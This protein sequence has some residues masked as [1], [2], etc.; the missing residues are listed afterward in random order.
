V[1]VLLV[2]DIRAWLDDA[3][4]EYDLLSAVHQSDYFRAHILGACVL[5]CRNTCT[6][7]YG[8]MYVDLDTI[9]FDTLDEWFALL[10][11]HTMVNADWSPAN[12]SVTMGE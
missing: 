5:R 7:A 12:E 8:G 2:G 6:A 11:S 10:A 4:R 9:A 1:R 3:P